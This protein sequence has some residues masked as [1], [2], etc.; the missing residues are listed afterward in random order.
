MWSC[1]GLRGG[2]NFCFGLIVVP[3]VTGPRSHAVA[4][5][6]AAVAAG[7]AAGCSHAGSPAPSATPP[8]PGR[9]AGNVTAVA[10]YLGGLAASG[11]F[12]GTVL[13]ARDGRVLLDAGYG[14]ADRAARTPN[15]P[16]TIFQVG[17]VTK[18]FTAM[19]IAILAQQG[20]LR[21]AGR[22][23]AYLPSCPPA[24]RRITIAELLTH[25]SGIANWSSWRLTVPL[26][27]E[28]TDP[29]RAIVAQAQ[30]EPLAFRPGHRAAYSN[31]GYVVLGDIIQQVSRMTYAA[32]LQRH[33]FGPLGMT[34]TGVY[35]GGPPGPGHALGYLASGAVAETILTAWSTAAGA[36]YSTTGD[37]DRW[38]QALITGH[39]R[40]VVP[41]LL[42]Q[43]LTVHAPCPYQTCPLPAD[44]GYG[45]GWFVGGSGAAKLA[46]HSGSVDGFWAYNGFYPA[47]D[48]T[49]VILS[50][51]DTVAINPLSAR[52]NQLAAA[53]VK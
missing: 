51:L 1:P 17:S 47:R 25:T 41:A 19:A 42:R 38:D 2:V 35:Q 6:T 40:L 3:D 7:L 9:P 13:V 34:R 46:N 4:L 26:P 44:Q 12:T 45:Y 50:N 52:L 27:G 49:V 16:A 5:A 29:V 24:W 11:R 28:A 8:A 21:L 10:A 20:R 18:Q 22:A 48:A 37:L 30:R 14:L 43:I 32:F 33:I 53:P 31:P 23:C 36:V 15:R 39:P